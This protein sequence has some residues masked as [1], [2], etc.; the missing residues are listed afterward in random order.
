MGYA[1]EAVTKSN[2]T[3]PFA[4]DRGIA[5]SILGRVSYTVDP[6][7][8]VAIEWAARQGGEGVYVKGEFSQSFGQHVR[9]T[10]TGVG[11]GGDPDDFLG[12]YRRNSHGSLGLRFSF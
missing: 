6:R 8:T 9:I 7:R 11:I 3:F 10:F 2:D 1:G 12:Q 5:K 4:P